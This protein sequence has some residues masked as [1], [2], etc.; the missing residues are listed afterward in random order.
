MGSN[1]TYMFCVNGRFISSIFI[2]LLRQ[3]AN[4]KAELYNSIAVLNVIIESYANIA[5]KFT[6]QFSFIITDQTH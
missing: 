6:F 2:Q 5:N 4:E 1:G 3:K